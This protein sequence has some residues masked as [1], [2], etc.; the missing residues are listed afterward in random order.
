MSPKAIGFLI[1]P[2]FEP[3]TLAH[4]AYAEVFAP[5]IFIKQ[6]DGTLKP[7]RMLVYQGHRCLVTMLFKVEKETDQYPFTYPLLESLNTF[8]SQHV[9]AVSAQLEQVVSKVI[10]KEDPIRFLYYNR[11]NLAVK[12]SN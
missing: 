10:V 1:G 7:F 9:P 11:L 6:E 8:L 4:D 12:F 2:V 5:K 3:A